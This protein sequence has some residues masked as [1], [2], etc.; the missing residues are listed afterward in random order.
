MDSTASSAPGATYTSCA[1]VPRP[2][3]LPMLRVRPSS[4]R[5]AVASTTEP[6][7]SGGVPKTIT[8]PDGRSDR[9][10]GWKKS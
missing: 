1:V 9:A 5:C 3:S 4:A 8:R 10:T 7:D 6:Q 2:N